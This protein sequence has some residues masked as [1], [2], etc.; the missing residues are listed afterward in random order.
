[1][2][3]EQWSEVQWAYPEGGGEKFEFA[4]Q[5]GLSE[6]DGQMWGGVYLKHLKQEE[7]GRWPYTPGPITLSG[8][9]E[10]TSPDGRTT[11]TTLKEIMVV[12]RG[13]GTSWSAGTAPAVSGKW[14]LKAVIHL[15]FS[16]I[17]SEQMYSAD[18]TETYSAEFTL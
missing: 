6:S 1:M 17:P 13:S 9:V 15:Q 10:L 8:S 18:F 16:N 14:T 5:L 7:Y 3:S 12:Y 11:S 4:H 2:A